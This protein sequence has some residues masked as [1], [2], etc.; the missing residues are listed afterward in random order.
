MQ[1][2]LVVS[3]YKED[4][5]WISS[6]LGTGRVARV[7]VYNKGGRTLS[8]GDD[9]VVVVEAPNV[10]RE[11]ETFLRHII[12]RWDDIPERIWFCQ[13][14]PFEHSPDFVRLLGSLEGYGS[15]PFWSMSHRYKSALGIPPNHMVDLN[16]AFDVAG[17]RCSPYFVRGMQLVGHC[18]FHDHGI[19]LVMDEFRSLYKVRDAFIYLSERLGIARPGPITEFA[20]S[21][22]FYTLGGCIRRHPRWVYEETRSFLME[23]DEQAGCQGFVLERYWPYLLTG[24]SCESLFDCYRGLLSDVPVAV[25]NSF[26]KRV[27]FKAPG[28]RDVVE[29]PHSFVC[30][31]D[32][33][34]IRHLPG[35]DLV[36]ADI[37]EE[38]CGSLEGADA[39]L[40]SCARLGGSSR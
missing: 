33:E 23:D 25:W 28:W 38:E 18:S 21:A 37:R 8:F 6:A 7:F 17:L 16:D 40:M 19:G 20:Y 30:F 39:F 11:G 3:A 9:R 27:W 32:G 1:G 29:N 34:R 12:E 36:G 31:F 35:I 10:G 2:D 15:M 22:C 26:G 14:D 13:G 4:L 24:R 5:S